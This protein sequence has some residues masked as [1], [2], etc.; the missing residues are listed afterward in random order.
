M[1]RSLA[2]F[3]LCFGL[4]C[5][6]CSKDTYYETPSFSYDGTTFYSEDVKA[7]RIAATAD[8]FDAIARQPEA[9]DDIIRNGQSMLMGSYQDLLPLK[10]Q[11]YDEDRSLARGVALKGLFG[12]LSRNPELYVEQGRASSIFLGPFDAN[13]L[14]EGSGR[15]RGEAVAGLFEALSRQPEAASDLD[16][17]AET[18]LGKYAPRLFPESTMAY[19]RAIASPALSSAIARQ[20]EMTTT[21][22]AFARKYLN[23][24]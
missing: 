21:L 9:A 11:G 22:M 6:G 16:A 17:L 23:T 10:G 5:A 2:L 19:A 18:Y 1:T 14:P 13:L 15:G 20:P 7:S 12:S 3:A 24:L 4:A 8:I